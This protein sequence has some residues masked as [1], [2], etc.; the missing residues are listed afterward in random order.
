MNLPIRLFLLATSSA[1]ILFFVVGT[2]TADHPQ[3]A[4]YKDLQLFVQSLKLIRSNYVEDV[5]SEALLRGARKGLVESLDPYGSYVEPERVKDLARGDLAGDIGLTL[6][7]GSSGFLR[8]LTVRPG[9]PAAREGV[10]SGR[11]LRAIDGQSTRD[12]S[13]L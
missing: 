10:R 11:W 12:I 3:P 5:D 2:I 7:R 1:L 6:G 8:I 4:A 13:L 9:S